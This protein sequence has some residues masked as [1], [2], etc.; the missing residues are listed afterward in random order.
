MTALATFMPDI[1]EEHLEELGFLWSQRRSAVWDPAYTIRELTDLE[2]RIQAHLHG[3]LVV[4]QKALPMLVER[5]GA[6]DGMT[7][8][9]AAFALLHQEVEAAPARVIAAF[10]VA[11]GENVDALCQALSHGPLHPNH[12]A[13]QALWTSGGL[14]VAVAAGEILAFHGT[15]RAS[16][17]DLRRFLAHDDATVR[18]RGWK[19]A[20]HLGA[21][22]NPTI[23][24]GA[25]LGDDAGVRREALEAAAWSRDPGLLAFCREVA[26]QPSPEVMDALYILAVLGGPEDLALLDAI[27]RADAL[28]PARFRILG[29]Y[30]HPAI[31]EVLLQEMWNPDPA[32]AAAAAAA[33]AKITGCDV[34]S[35]SRVTVPP[36]DGPPGDE[37]DAEFHDEVVLPD[38]EKA[39][40]E[41]QR[42][43]P[44]FV[45]SSRVCRGFDLSEA[46]DNE[47]FT[48]LDMESRWEILLRANHREAWNGSPLSVEVYPQRQAWDRA[49][50]L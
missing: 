34:E 35:A 17:T 46:V 36:A 26:L 43:W 24:T 41:W 47:A 19:L 50:A 28:G 22:S 18:R 3:V 32:A 31:V 1:L 48:R 44:G 40:F 7:A 13:I 21:A 14:A 12:P 8:F 30:G 49:S 16:A 39:R 15:L 29:A 20:G 6:D 23:L 10:E 9:G 42:A 38:P 4:G 5:L 37:F 25:L 33:F 27:G 45:Q 11:E 2:Q